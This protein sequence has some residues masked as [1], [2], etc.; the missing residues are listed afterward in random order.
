MSTVHAL[1]RARA[2]GD[3]QGVPPPSVR[4][5]TACR[6]DAGGISRFDP[7]GRRR[8]AGSIFDSAGFTLIE[9]LTVIAIVG[10]LAAILIPTAGGAR[11]AA[12][13]ARTR[14]QFSQWAAAFEAF[15]QEYGTYPQLHSGGVLVN[16]GAGTDG[17]AEHLFHD[18]LAG[19][20]RDP[21]AANW[22]ANRGGRIPPFAEQQNPRRIRFLTFAA[23][24]FVTAADVAAGHNRADELNLLRDAFH[25]TSI[26]VIVDRNRDG[27][28]NGRDV[29]GGFPGVTPAGGG[30]AI[31]PATRLSAGATGGVHAGVIFYSAPP[32]ATHE[33]DLV[34]NVP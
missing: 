21:S 9:L 16:H 4:H 20:R 34:M 11:T 22:L 24:D 8:R 7:G 3:A 19:Q 14:A 10:I 32:G 12:N 30:T 15:R 33:D 25:G 27:V 6:P 2:D 29:D 5:D 26:A 17:Q 31:R 23:S 18:V 1:G 13:K 28:I